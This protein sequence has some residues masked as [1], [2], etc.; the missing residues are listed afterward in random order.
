[1]DIPSGKRLHDYGKSPSLMGKLTNLMAVFNSY[2]AILNCQRVI[3][4]QC[5]QM[6]VLFIENIQSNKWGTTMDAINLS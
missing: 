3:V 4:I 2:A 1:M 5:W 6:I